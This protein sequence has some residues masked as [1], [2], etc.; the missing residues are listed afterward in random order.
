MIR[1]P[2]NQISTTMPPRE[3]LADD[4]RSEAEIRAAFRTMDA[5][6]VAGEKLGGGRD[7]GG[8]GWR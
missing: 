1:R 5:A 6:A 7:D 8:G 2:L 4:L 3:T